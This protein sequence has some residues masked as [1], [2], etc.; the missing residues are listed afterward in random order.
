[1]ITAS[2]IFGPVALTIVYSVYLMWR[3]S[4]ESEG[5]NAMKEIARAIQVGSKAYLNRQYKTVAIVA[6]ILFALIYISPLGRETALAFLVGAVASAVAGYIG[7]MV[8]VR[9]NSRTT[10]A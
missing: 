1:M 6:A 9:S 8:A 3:L 7:M 5:T 2:L 4:R 10:E